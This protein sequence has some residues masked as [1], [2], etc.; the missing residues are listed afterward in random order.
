MKKY[1]FLIFCLISTSA[2]SQTNTYTPKEYKYTSFNGD[3]Y[4]MLLYEGK[5]VNLLI[6]DTLLHDNETLTVMTNMLDSVW[7]FYYGMAKKYPNPGSLFNGKGYVAFVNNTCGAGCGL[8]GSMGVEVGDAEWVNIY[9]NI[10]YIKN[11]AILKVAYY[12]MGR[13]FF[14]SD[15]DQKLSVGQFWMPEPFATTGYLN[16]IYYKGLYLKDQ[17]ENE[18]GYKFDLV[19]R[20]N[21]FILDTIPKTI[22]DVY[23]NSWYPNA[24]GNQGFKP[25][26][27]SGLLEK[28]CHDYALTFIENFY[29][30][31]YK[32]PNTNNNIQEAYSNFCIA[33]S[34]AVNVNL[35]PFFS[36][37]YKI[38]LNDSR[39]ESSLAD[40][41]L[42]KTKF[43][44]QDKTIFGFYAKD[45]TLVRVKAIS[46]KVNSKIEYT[47]YEGNV[48]NETKP[49]LTSKK[50]YFFIKNKRF[51]YILWVK[52]TDGSDFVSS[53]QIKYSYRGNL[54]TDYSFE[55]KPNKYPTNS[56]SSMEFYGGNYNTLLSATKDSLNKN[57]GNYS[58]KFDHTAF[59]GCGKFTD[60][61]FP[62]LDYSQS[63]IEPFKGKYR[64]SAKLLTSNQFET[65]P[66]I[67]FGA[68]LNF[69]VKFG[70]TLRLAGLFNSK[71]NVFE[72]YFID[73][74]TNEDTSNQSK[75]NFFTIISSGIKGKLYVDDISVKAI[76]IPEPVKIL[77]INSK[78]AKKVEAVYDQKDF[79]SMLVDSAQDIS[80][81]VIV[82][83]K[84]STFSTNYQT[85]KSAKNKF[86]FSIK[87][88]GTYYMRAYA[89]NDF[90]QSEYSPI[91]EILISNNMPVAIAG[92]DQTFNEGEM[93]NLDGSASY[94]PDKN[95]ITYSWIPPKGII[96]SLSSIS[97]P[98]FKAPEVKN[99]TIL[100]FSLIVNDGL[101]S[102][103]PSTVNISVKNVIK[104]GIEDHPSSNLA[105][106][107]NPT[108]GILKIEGLR[109][110]QENRISVYSVDGILIKTKLSNSITET[111]DL[112]D[113]VS[114]MYLL[115]INN[116]P[117]KIIKE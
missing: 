94:D 59:T 83:S 75:S 57:T 22:S 60:R 28:L 36:K 50:D 91:K 113:Q 47:V 25:F 112:S 95:A 12:E 24:Y 19:D 82:Y 85:I 6:T 23:Q 86:A 16:A 7:N 14:N 93:V 106:Y 13:N 54:I 51:D 63:Y 98:T 58:L 29:K 73:V 18:L 96:F 52:A 67:V 53:E 70:N 38:P 102:S 109:A 117:V 87:D 44:A 42:L 90:G 17:Y 72:N 10:K 45:S 21:E 110:N 80:E 76:L 11:G 15:I 115:F 39:V 74:D 4:N 56:S 2:F 68:G 48:G 100:N 116:Q 62:T 103:L 3:K 33:T 88:I 61:D 9:N 30:E 1:L 81:Y 8:V 55:S 107:P 35:K 105:T 40:L 104:T 92:K 65:C 26:F 66:S 37:G 79:I 69:G 41:P 43:I 114:G 84:D 77:S 46:G 31:L 108:T 99:D 89:T 111:I 32:L 78:Q 49:I 71:S 5:S 64:V 20:A 101:I 27:N 34:R 97:N